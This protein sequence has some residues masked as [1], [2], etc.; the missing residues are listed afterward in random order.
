MAKNRIQYHHNPIRY[1][2]D[3]G[4]KY[5]MFNALPVTVLRTVNVYL[6]EYFTLE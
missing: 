2:F 5:S 3:F 6:I 4:E 1:N